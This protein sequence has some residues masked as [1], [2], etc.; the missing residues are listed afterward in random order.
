MAREPQDVYDDW[1]DKQTEKLDDLVDKTY[2]ADDPK[3]KVKIYDD[4]I[5]KAEAFVQEC[6]KRDG[7]PGIYS[8]YADDAE[9]QLRDIIKEKERYIAEEYDEDLVDW[10]EHLEEEKERAAL[11]KKRD[12]VKA[13]ILADLKTCSHITIVDLE[14]KYP[15][16]KDQ[17]RSAVVELDDAG[18]VERFKIKNRL[19]VKLMLEE[20]IA[21]VKEVRK[22]KNPPRKT[23][24]RSN[25]CEY[26]ENDEK[27]FASEEEKTRGRSNFSD[28][29]AKEKSLSGSE[30]KPEG[31]GS[32]VL[33]TAIIFAVIVYFFF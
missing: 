26:E 31:K 15:D 25:R 23:P 6:R 21:K 4:A 7:E 20:D 17:I 2:D 29:A 30:K 33:L 8:P 11:Q 27:L 12:R 16:F 32:T 24:E 22:P 3:K 19:A 13:L 9:K 18:M 5:A 10:N 28:F 1:Y 14:K